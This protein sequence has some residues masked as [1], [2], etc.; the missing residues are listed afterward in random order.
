MKGIGHELAPKKIMPRITLNGFGE[1][2]SRMSTKVFRHFEHVESDTNKKELVV[3][4]DSDSMCSNS[5]GQLCPYIE[6]VCT[7]ITNAREIAGR[8]GSA[9]DVDIEVPSALDGFYVHGKKVE[10]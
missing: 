7:D 4:E 10:D 2:T 8:L 3:K 9:L 5:E 1:K 6:V